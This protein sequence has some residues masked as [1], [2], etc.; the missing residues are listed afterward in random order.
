MP[1]PPPVGSASAGA[2]VSANAPPPADEGR[3]K[4]EAEGGVAD[5]D[6][7]RQR[8]GGGGGAG[9]AGGAGGE[10]GSEG[11][12]EPAAP[13]GPEEV[14]AASCAALGA[15]ADPGLTQLGAALAYNLSLFWPTTVLPALEARGDADGTEATVLA[16]LLGAAAGALPTLAD[17]E[18]V[19]RALSVLGHL[20]HARDD[21]PLAL[22]VSLDATAVLAAL[23]DKAAA[24]GHAKLREE[25]AALL[26]DE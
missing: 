10:G 17:A 16:P 20:L 8:G 1:P 24:L 4:R 6:A 11:G 15:T 13:A 9:G 19:G 18:S 2:P 7:K 23:T 22:A 14:V 12:G 3:C 25:V 26:S 21:V 5:E